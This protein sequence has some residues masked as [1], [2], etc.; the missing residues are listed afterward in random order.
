MARVNGRRRSVGLGGRRRLRDRQVFDESL[1]TRARAITSMRNRTKSRACLARLKHT[2]G[3]SV[4]RGLDR[5]GY[6][7]CIRV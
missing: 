3:R 7:T 6:S 5:S 1:S 2:P 4:A